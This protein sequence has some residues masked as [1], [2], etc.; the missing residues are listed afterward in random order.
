[1]GGSTCQCRPRLESVFELSSRLSENDAGRPDADR[2][3]KAEDREY[4]A[5]DSHELGVV[6]LSSEVAIRSRCWGALHV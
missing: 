1:M 2:V 4:Q 6:P 5:R 3:P